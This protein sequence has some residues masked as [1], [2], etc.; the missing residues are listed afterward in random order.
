MP[1]NRACWLSAALTVA[2]LGCVEKPVNQG[3]HPAN[4]PSAD[5]SLDVQINAAVPANIP[6]E[7]RGDAMV[8]AL[9]APVRE[10]DERCMRTRGPS[11]LR[12]LRVAYRMPERMRRILQAVD[13]PYARLWMAWI[14][15][16]EGEESEARTYLA[17]ARVELRQD[18]ARTAVYQ[19]WLRRITEG[20][21]GAP[22]LTEELIAEMRA[23]LDHWASLDPELGAEAARVLP[24]SM[25]ARAGAAAVIAFRPAQTASDALATGVVLRCVGRVV[26]E[27]PEESQRLA[28]RG[29][30]TELE[31]SL[32]ALSPRPGAS[33]E[34]VR[35]RAFEPLFSPW[36]AVA[37]FDDAALQRWSRSA[38]GASIRATVGPWLRA[39]TASMQTV[40]QAY[41]PMARQADAAVTEAQCA[42]R[43]RSALNSAAQLWA[44]SPVVVGDRDL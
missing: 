40:Q 38:A 2:S 7:R 32:V 36:Y 24:C 26:D 16:F 12:L 39:R 19:Q 42:L 6:L 27:R 11:F 28:L 8:I 15:Q 4:P 5:A 33:T 34:L 41:C 10:C 22:T 20:R 21:S 13:T 9:R 31:T 29:A 43:V 37:P 23:Q 1:V 3:A 18:A 30:M 17:E 44:S 14:A 35:A 25:L